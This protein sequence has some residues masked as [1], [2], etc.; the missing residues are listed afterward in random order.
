M[1]ITIETNHGGVYTS[2]E[3][4]YTVE[5]AARMFQGLLVASGYHPSSVDGIFDPDMVECW[6]LDERSGTDLED[7]YECHS[8]TC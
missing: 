1:K 6:K 4:A 7:R 5:Q 3:D 8:Q 2:C